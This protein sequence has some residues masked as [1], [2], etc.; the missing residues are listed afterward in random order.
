M[1]KIFSSFVAILMFFSLNLSNVMAESSD[2]VNTDAP[3]TTEMMLE[4]NIKHIRA[5][6]NYILSDGSYLVD[7]STLVGTGL[8]GKVVVVTENGIYANGKILETIA[9]IVGTKVIGD[10]VEGAIVYV[11]GYTGP[12]LATVAINAIVTLVSAHPAGFFALVALAAFTAAVVMSYKT[13]SGNE[14]VLNPSGHG[15]TCKYSL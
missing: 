9:V 10:F 7:M 13:T 5:E 12:E 8:E 4:T 6:D 15:Y 1:K 3:E 2:V 14:C 11:S